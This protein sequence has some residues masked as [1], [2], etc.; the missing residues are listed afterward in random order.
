MRYEIE[1]AGLDGNFMAMEMSISPLYHE[2][3][4]NWLH[5]CE[6]VKFEDRNLVKGIG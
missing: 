2:E 6:Y 1:W 4:L 5:C 3:K